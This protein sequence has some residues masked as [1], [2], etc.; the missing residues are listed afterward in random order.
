MGDLRCEFPTLD[1]GD[2]DGD[3]R[4]DI[5]TASLIT[6]ERSDGTEPPLIEIWKQLR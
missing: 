5:I 3:G 2:I 4:L 1:L 6:K